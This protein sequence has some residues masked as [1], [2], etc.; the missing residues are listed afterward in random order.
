[1]TFLVV[2]TQA[3]EGGDAVA[4]QLSAA[5]L[6]VEHWPL[7]SLEPVPLDAI[8]P[9]LERLSGYHWIFL[10]SPSAVRLVAQRMKE[11]GIAWPADVRAGLVGPG[12]VDAFRACFGSGPAVDT[13]LQ[14]PHDAAHLVQALTGA[15]GGLSAAAT[16]VRALV[17][18]RPDGRARWVEM[19]RQKAEVDVV[20]AYTAEPVLKGPPEQLMWRLQRMKRAGGVVAWVIGASSQLDTLLQVLPAEMTDWA[21]RQ[22][23]L[24]P[25]AAILAHAEACGFDE[26]AVYDDRRDLVE[27]LQY[28]TSSHGRALGQPAD[29]DADKKE[30][31]VLSVDQKN[32]SA[33][34]DGGLTDDQPGSAHRASQAPSA[35]TS[36]GSSPAAS[37]PLPA[38]PP[39][40][41]LSPSA[42][43]PPPPPL[44]PVPSPAVGPIAAGDFRR[45]AG[46]W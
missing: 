39:P 4:R 42:L 15:G 17:L 3:A 11:L 9:V 8:R 14:P 1:M 35:A 26:G 34:P 10:P 20:A 24:V 37:E 13:P 2:L 40:S 32:S 16:P 43:P 7:V 36:P 23:L 19:L 41:P 46:L 12:S 25:H 28:V 44:P 29:T 31:S 27:R 5:G 6:Q 22:P 45:G 21:K 30:V 18:N 33:V 38:S